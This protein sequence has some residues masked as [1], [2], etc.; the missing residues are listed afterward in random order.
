MNK[1]KLLREERGLTVRKLSELINIKHENISRYENDKRD[2]S[3]DLLRVFASFFEVS[4][5]YLLGYSGYYIYV[6]YNNI[7]LKVNEED[8]NYLFKNNFIYFDDNNH[9][10]VNLN[11]LFGF[12]HN[13]DLSEFIIEMNRCCKINE[14][15]DKNSFGIVGE[16]YVNNLINDVEIILDSKFIKFMINSIKD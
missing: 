14:L 9:R 8:Y 4:I 1:I 16:G 15:F 10:C 7:N 2:I 6:K 5:D 3:T 13:N 11:K 12:N